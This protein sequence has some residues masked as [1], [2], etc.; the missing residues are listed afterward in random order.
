MN[1]N[2]IA[3]AKLATSIQRKLVLI[4]GA[5][6]KR[7]LR[8][9]LVLGYWRGRLRLNGDANAERIDPNRLGRLGADVRPACCLIARHCSLGIA[10]LR[11]PSIPVPARGEKEG[12]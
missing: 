1:R 10:A 3:P 12:N 6:G 11:R 9:R 2:V 8:G 4:V 5:I 7:D